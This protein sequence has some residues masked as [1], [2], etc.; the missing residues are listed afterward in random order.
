MAWAAAVFSGCGGGGGS[1]GSGDGPPNPA[2][3]SSASNSGGGGNPGPQLPTCIATAVDGCVSKEEF[4]RLRDERAALVL[5]DPEFRPSTP[6][7]DTLTQPALETVN[8]HRA[9]AALAVKYGANVKPG[10]GVTIGILDSG[11]DLDHGELDDAD[12][13]ETFLQNLPNEE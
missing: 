6:D 7:P 2:P 9:H 10:E 8:V 11:V 1:G 12:I 13:S 5:A 3:L 4:D